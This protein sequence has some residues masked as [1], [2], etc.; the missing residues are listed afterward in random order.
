MNQ[1][2][3]RTYDNAASRLDISLMINN[4]VPS[5]LLPAF[6]SLTPVT[7]CNV[8]FNMYRYII[9]NKELLLGCV[10]VLGQ[11]SWCR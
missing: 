5:L 2:S 8:C 3:D 10:E 6:V 9:W 1:D 7:V 11:I 4:A